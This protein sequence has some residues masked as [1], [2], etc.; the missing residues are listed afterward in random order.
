VE[1]VA[2]LNL[3]RHILFIRN[4][5]YLELPGNFCREKIAVVGCW[6]S[7]A[8]RGDFPRCLLRYPGTLRVPTA[9]F[10]AKPGN[11]LDIDFEGFLMKMSV[12]LIN[13][14]LCLEAFPRPCSIADLITS[15]CRC[16]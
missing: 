5:D 8:A 11:Q 15:F 3:T 7:S 12:L 13:C 4:I 14:S 9:P 2:I 10:M 6:P 1:R 16:A